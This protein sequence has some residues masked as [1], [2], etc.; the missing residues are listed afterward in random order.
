[1]NL[2]VSSPR[3]QESAISIQSKSPYNFSKIH[4]NVILILQVIFVW[5]PQASPLKPFMHT[6]CPTYVLHGH[7]ILF[8]L[9][10]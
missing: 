6:F 1:M 3:P 7:P 8:F 9:I 4:I 2:E 5:F 10:L